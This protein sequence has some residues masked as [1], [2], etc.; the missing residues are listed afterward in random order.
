[1]GNHWFRGC[2][3]GREAMSRQGVRV[4]NCFAHP[5][6]PGEVAVALRQPYGC[7]NRLS[8]GNCNEKQV[9]GGRYAGCLHA[10]LSL[11][12]LTAYCAF[13]G[14]LLTWSAVEFGTHV[15]REFG[16]E[17]RITNSASRNELASVWTSGGCARYWY[18]RHSS[19]G[20]RMGIATLNRRLA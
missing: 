8:G 1:V 13:Y 4:K 2:G 15:L 10:A 20:P 6:V 12:G 16:S 5:Y 18:C 3:V 11:I 17:S 19:D 14:S 9:G 7:P